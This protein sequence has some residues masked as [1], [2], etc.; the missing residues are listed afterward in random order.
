MLVWIVFAV[1]TALALAAVF[2]P[3]LRKGAATP[4]RADVD[5]AVFMDQLAELDRDVARGAIGAAEAAAARNEIARRIL[6]LP[7][8]AG[9][10]SSG[11]HRGAAAAVALV[12]IPLLALAL[13]LR[14]GQ[15]HLP[16]VPL[17]ERM[18]RAT[19]TGD[20]PAM[21]AQVEAHLRENPADLQGWLVIAPAYRRSNRFADAARA[22]EK[23]VELGA[24]TSD[25]YADLGE[26]IVFGGQGMVSAEASRAFQDALS[27]DPENPK[28]RYYAALALRQE[29]KTEEAIAAWKQ[30]PPGAPPSSARSWPQPPP[31]WRRTTSRR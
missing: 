27:R 28:A 9:P 25:T 19:E 26:M 23:I 8:D 12:V 22:Y 6:S 16:D 5:R 20:F 2:L 24:A 11:A 21:V 7:A 31:A 13:Y 15:P 17:A 1:L 29:G 14:A 3:A 30:L 18:A 10:H 4:A